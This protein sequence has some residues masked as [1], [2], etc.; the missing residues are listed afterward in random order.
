MQ[1]GAGKCTT[2]TNRDDGIGKQIMKE[3]IFVGDKAQG[4]GAVA[5]YANRQLEQWM[6]QWQIEAEIIADTQRREVEERASDGQAATKKGRWKS[7]Q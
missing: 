4:V 3:A 6:E 1:T 5:I 2:S 7:P